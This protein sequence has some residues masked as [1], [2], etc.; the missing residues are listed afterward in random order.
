MNIQTLYED[1]N[2]LIVNKPSGLIVHSDGKT[3]EPTLTAWILEKHPEMKEVGEPLRLRSGQAPNEEVSIDR[4]G[5]VHRLD[6]ETSGA[7]VLAKNQKAFLDLKK[8]FQNRKV[9]KKYH[10][11]VYGKIKDDDGTINLPI[12]RSRSDFRKWSAERGARGESREAVTHY[13]VLKKG[14][15]ATFV[16]AIPKTGRTHQIRV[17]FKAIHHPVVG[18]KLYAPNKPTLFGLN[19]LALHSFSLGFESIDGKRID[20]AAEYPE[21]FEKAMD[22]IVSD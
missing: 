8:K 1:E 16:E 19:R 7:L 12:A 17:H 18:D 9:L 6:K 22:K 3:K 11:F 13:S 15:D 20:I 4:P 21:D 5:I 10:A 14:K 2:Y